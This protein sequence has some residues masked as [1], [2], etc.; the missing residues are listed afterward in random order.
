VTVI[1]RL[2]A[3]LRGVVVTLVRAPRRTKLVADRAALLAPRIAPVLKRNRA[4]G[5]VPFPA[6]RAQTM[7]RSG[8]VRTRRDPVVQG[9]R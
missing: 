7:M 8:V 1:R 3:A 9:P 6:L 2:K 5:V 4:D